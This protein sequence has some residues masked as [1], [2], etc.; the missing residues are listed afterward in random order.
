[1]RPNRSVFYGGSSE[2]LLAS[3]QFKGMS[4]KLTV[5]ERGMSPRNLTK[6]AL[7]SHMRYMR[8]IAQLMV[9]TARSLAP[10]SH[11]DGGYHAGSLTDS[12]VAVNN[13]PH[14]GVYSFTIGVDGDKWDSDYDERYRRRYHRKPPWG[15]LKGNKNGILYLL[16]DHWKTIVDNLAEAN[17]HYASGTIVKSIDGKRRRINRKPLGGSTAQE[18]AEA[19]QSK[20]YYPEI[21]PFMAGNK[22]GEKFLYNAVRTVWDKG[23][24]AS[25]FRRFFQQTMNMNNGL[26]MSRGFDD[27]TNNIGA[28]DPDKME[29]GTNAYSYLSAFAEP[30]G[31]KGFFI[32]EFSRAK[33]PNS[34]LYATK[35]VKTKVHTSSKYDINGN[36]I[37]I[38]SL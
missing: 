21:A 17:A 14:G 37:S 26:I 27:I 4:I 15:T 2:S 18:R 38:P 19:K 5:S 32:P 20:V 31:T 30:R 10:T 25:Q 22:V 12:I 36:P 29:P 7:A 28:L 34:W 3:T 24:N 35:K 1:M 11:I 6:L 9:Y 8:K 23:A 33:I 16:H 13:Q